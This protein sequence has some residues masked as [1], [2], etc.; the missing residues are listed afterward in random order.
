MTT[1]DPSFEALGVSDAVIETLAARGIHAPFP[2]QQMVIEDATEGR[3]TL[4]K[5]KTGSGKTLGFAI[6]IVEQ[7][8]P[9]ATSRPLALV[10]VPTRELATQVKEDFTDIAKAKHL[11][12]KAVYGG[13]N[14]KEQAKGVEQA[15]ILIATPGRLDD[16]VERRM[17]YLKHVQIFVLDEADRMLDMGFQ[18]Q[19][20]RIVRHLPKDRQTMFFSATLDGAVGRIAEVYTRNPVRHEIESDSQ[21]VD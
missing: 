10:L 16:L 17:V 6:P 2:I 12:V 14:V 13:T 21:T 19:V 20:D 11:R 18:P 4:A 1:L 8:D 7:L 5:S 15:H 9:D 3:D